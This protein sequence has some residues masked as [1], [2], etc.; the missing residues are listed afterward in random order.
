MNRIALIVTKNLFTVIGAY[1][2]LKKFA[3]RPDQYS[4][5]EV[6]DYIRGVLDKVMGTANVELTVTGL[7]HIPQEDGFMLYGNHQGMFDV[8]AIASTCANPVS[9][10]YKQELKNIPL[11]KQLFA[12]TESYAL[13]RSD[14]R[15]GIAVIQAVT[16]QVECG[17][18]YVIFPEGTRSKT[19]NRMNE[20]HAGSF[21]CALKSK[22]PI[23]PIAFVDCYKV[24]DQKGSR[25][26]SAQIHYLRPVTYEEYKDLKTAEIAQLVK[27][28]VQ[29]ALD[30]FAE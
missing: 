28:R 3:R 27:A 19:G 10:V 6:W 14:A 12:V 13:D 9:F 17:R 8:V 25:K 21:R 11:L 29:Q 7:E 18:N 1:I 4:R 15:Q 30:Q 20:W 16:K 22:C 26:V 2:K 5:E 23:V 24:F